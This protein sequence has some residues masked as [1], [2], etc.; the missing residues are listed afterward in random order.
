MSMRRTSVLA[1]TTMTI[2]GVIGV[3]A[4]LILNVF[5]FDKFDAYGEV[6]IPGNT[7]LELPA[8]EVTVS[9]HSWVSGDNGLL[10][11]ELGMSLFPPPGVAEPQVRESIGSSTTVNGD[12]R[13]RVWVAQIPAA[14]IYNV[15][16]DGDVSGFVSPR[17][18]FG[19]GSPYWA[20]T[21]GFAGL[22]G[23]AALG[24][25]AYV[26]TRVRSTRSSPP[27]PLNN[28]QP[29]SSYEPS[30]DGVRI[31]QLKSLAAL[32]DSGALTEAEF[33]AEKRRVLG[34]G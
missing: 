1:L 7:Q 9:F 34:G 18:A 14:G 16:V 10:V 25:I 32:R 3:I 29:T 23:V 28:P 20:L 21:W 17:L 30:D 26:L 15:Q 33:E 5:V 13:R 6:K 24:W 2:G 19:H 11:P 31:E 22:L 4:T 12:A 27:S 8:G